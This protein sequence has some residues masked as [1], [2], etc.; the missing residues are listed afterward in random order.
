MKRFTKLAVFMMLILSVVFA[1][2]ACGVDEI[3]M[4]SNPTRTTY[5]QGQELDLTGGTLKVRTGNDVEEIALNSDGVTLSGYDKDKIGSQEVTVNYKEKTTSFNVTVIAR[6]AVERYAQNY[7]VGEPFVKEGRLVLARDDGS[8]YTVNLSD[9]GVEISGFDSTSAG[10]KTLTVNY[11]SSGNSYTGT[12]DVNVYAIDEAKSSFTAPNKI[13]YQSHQA[14]SELDVAG[15]YFVLSS[16]NGEYTKNV[17]LTKDMV[18]GFDPSLATS[19]NK[20]AGNEL[21]QPLTV[22]YAGVTKSFDVYITYSNVSAFKAAAKELTSID[23]TNFDAAGSEL[24]VALTSD[25][26]EKATEAAALYTDLTFEDQ[27]YISEDELLATL[28]AAAV[29]GLNLWKGAFDDLAHTLTLDESGAVLLVCDEYDSVKEDYQKLQQDDYPLYVYAEALTGYANDFAGTLLF[30]EGDD[31]VYIEDYL[32]GI[33]SAD[34]FKASLPVLKIMLDFYEALKDF[35]ESATDSQ[36]RQ[37]A[38]MIQ[39]A[40]NV[41]ASSGLTVDQRYVYEYPLAWREDLFDILYKYYTTANLGRNESAVAVLTNAYLPGE[42]GDLFDYLMAGLQETYIISMLD[43]ANYAAAQESGESGVPSFYTYDSSAFLAYYEG[44]WKLADEL[45]LI[46]DTDQ[47]DSTQL[48]IFNN[49]SFVIGYSEDGSAQA[50]NFAYLFSYLRYSSYGYSYHANMMVDMDDLDALWKCYGDFLYL[51]INDQDGTY[52]ESAAYGEDIEE[53]FEMFVAAPPTLQLAF[54]RSISPF[55]WSYSAPTYVLEYNYGEA[56]YNNEFTQIVFDY[57]LDKLTEAGVASEGGEDLLYTLLQAAE[58]FVLGNEVEEEALRFNELMASVEDYY[59]KL[60]NNQ[61]KFDE[62]L[63]FL[64][65]KYHDLCNADYSS[66]DLGEWKEKIDAYNDALMNGYYGFTLT[67]YYYMGSYSYSYLSPMLA[68]YEK[69]T[70]LRDEILACGD[71]DVLNY[72]RYYMTSIEKSFSEDTPAWTLG[73]FSYDYAYFYFREECYLYL[74][75]GLPADSEGTY[76]LYDVYTLAYTTEEGEKTPEESLRPFLAAMSDLFWAPFGTDEYDAAALSKAALTE[77]TKLDAYSKMMFLDYVDGDESWFFNNVDTEFLEAM[78]AV[79]LAALP[80]A[81]REDQE[82]LEEIQ[83]E[84]SEITELTSWDL[85]QAARYYSYYEALISE[86]GYQSTAAIYL[87]FFKVCMNGGSY[88]VYAGTENEYTLT[89]EKG[90]MAAVSELKS[91]DKALY[92]SYFA[93]FY[94]YYEG[95]YNSLR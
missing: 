33:Y 86:Q 88:T 89:L 59:S 41:I 43:Q 49:S 82:K 95:V 45:H 4:G 40:L 42:L 65:T 81:D 90:V 80:E 92:D 54:L 12:F 73:T 56:G 19:A 78:Y 14:A 67:L 46:T 9:D 30:G 55:Y 58:A 17:A 84:V 8:V 16:A 2:T 48:F 29:Y 57:Y 25:K 27:R 53:L 26:G 35:P 6:F 66:V 74:M 47:A 34:E 91:E 76:S 83:N 44:A 63:G 68:A 38:A 70:M 1:F 37:N 85:F 20:G 23:W 32:G 75:Q 79:R 7:F 10:T 52:Q 5:V 87:E 64:Y 36:Y 61:G 39:R 94:G 13:A 31:A 28:R 24:P 51:L 60:G 72:F 93:D 50:L 22:R 62:I 11:V 15:G 69:A 77:F 3:S 21:R 18:E 71:E